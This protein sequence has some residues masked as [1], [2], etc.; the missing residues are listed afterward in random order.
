MTIRFALSLAAA[1]GLALLC[2]CATQGNPTSGPPT[3]PA[4][5]ASSPY[6]LYTHCGVHEALV[7]GTYFVADEALDDGHGNP[8]EGWNNPYQPGTIIVTGPKATFHDDA[9]HTVTF[10]ARPGATGFLKT[11]S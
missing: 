2:G 1:A 6:N 11:C 10:Q 5:A 4:A 9:G 3:G 7:Q 8:P